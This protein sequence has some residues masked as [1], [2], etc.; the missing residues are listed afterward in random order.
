RRIHALCQSYGVEYASRA[1]VAV[2][3]FD[4]ETDFDR[5]SQ[6][7]E[8]GLFKPSRGVMPSSH[9]VIDRHRGSTLYVGRRE[10]GRSIRGY[11][12]SMQL[13][14]R[15]GWFRVELELRSIGRRVPIDILLDPAGYFAGA[16]KFCADLVDNA[17]ATRTRVRTFR[18][19]VEL[20]LSRITDY[21]R[22]AYGPLIRLYRDA[23]VPDSAI[24]DRL[25]VGAS[26]LPRRLRVCSR[27]EILQVVGLAP[28]IDDLVMAH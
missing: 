4:D 17:R 19:T 2:D 23:G 8:A 6:A 5:M 26:G 21:G 16:C 27:E 3:C 12:K 15:R 14:R 9:A 20:S 18:R 13:A 24:L 28:P 1:D 11:E 25:T 10:N 7:Y 22:I